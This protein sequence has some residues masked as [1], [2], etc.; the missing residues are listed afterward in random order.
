MWK[1]TYFYNGTLTC[2]NDDADINC[3]AY[4]PEGK[5]PEEAISDTVDY[6]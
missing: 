6:I 4:K 2:F 3:I 1:V 5:T